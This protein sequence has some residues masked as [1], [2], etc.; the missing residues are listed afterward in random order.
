MKQKGSGQ[1]VY[2][3]SR[4]PIGNLGLAS[5]KL[6]LH[7]LVLNTS[8]DEF[9]KKLRSDFNVTPKRNDKQF[10]GIIDQLD[11][12]FDGRCRSFEVDLDIRGS[13]FEQNVWETLLTI[14]YV[15]LWS[16]KKVAQRI[17]SPRAYRAVGNAV[18]RNPIPVIIPCHRVIKSDLSIGGYGAGIEIKRK[19][20]LIEGVMDS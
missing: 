4:T 15:A 16:Y 14:P 3:I 6:G 12:Y 19:L 1:I 7:R 9:N 18:G 5:S 17:G 20:L 11:D 10:L 2:T 13:W 8:D